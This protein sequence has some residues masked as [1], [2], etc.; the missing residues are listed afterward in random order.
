[1]ENTRTEGFKSMDRDSKLIVYRDSPS[2]SLINNH[3]L[4]RRDLWIKDC[5]PT[6]NLNDRH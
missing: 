2:F 4:D 3:G 6:V 1:M 5:R